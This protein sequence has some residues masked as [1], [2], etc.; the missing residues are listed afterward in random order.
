MNMMYYF[1]F[2]GFWRFLQILNK[3]ATITYMLQIKFQDWKKK[4]NSTQKI[5]FS[6]EQLLDGI[7]FSFIFLFF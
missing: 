5:F 1:I 7:T 6:P 2:N 3:S 4:S